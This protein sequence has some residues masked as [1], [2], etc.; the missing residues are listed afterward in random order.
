[1]A[2]DRLEQLLD[3]CGRGDR[4]AFAAAVYDLT[5][6]RVFDLVLRVVRDPDRAQRC[7]REAYLQV[8][9]HAGRYR[10]LD[11]SALSWIA[12]LAYRQVQSGRDRY[13]P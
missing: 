7:T 6:T 10:R 1:M 9:R 13:S 8:W 4:A 12:T 11:G 5:A 2:G 3:R